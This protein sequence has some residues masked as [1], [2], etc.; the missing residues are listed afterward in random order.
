MNS[1][2]KERI[3]ERIWCPLCGQYHL[4]V[5]YKDGDGLIR[6]VILSEAPDEKNNINWRA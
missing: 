2:N 3:E 4:R 6:T 5:F 1:T